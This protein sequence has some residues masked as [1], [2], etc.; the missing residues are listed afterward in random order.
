M[1]A[2]AP[3]PIDD[4]M[5][6]ASAALVVTDYFEAE[7]HA[8]SA[9]RLSRAL[10]DFERMARICLPLQE[11][12]RQKRLLAE[13]AA[14]S[15]G[16]V[17]LRSI[18][19]GSD[20]MK[21]GCYL[22]QPPAIGA[23]ARALRE[24]FDAVRVPAAILTREPMT[25]LG[26]WPVVAVGQRWA[27]GASSVRTQVDPPPGVERDGSAMTH[28]RLTESVPLEWFLSAGEA[29][30]DEGIARLKPR[31]PA[32]GRVDDLLGFL[33]ALADH[34]KLHQRLAEACREAVAEHAAAVP[35]RQR[36]GDDDLSGF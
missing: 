11:A 26:R 25:R 34:E 9:L 35:S 7:R 12:R 19:A 24:R 5:E 10:G 27:G 3:T 20:W 30:G 14:N 21:P 17:V 8:L 2:A 29:L 31:A 22:L 4:L 1:S 16:C 13:G 33:D 36:F 6:R 23:D 32:V 28:D 18:A 15:G